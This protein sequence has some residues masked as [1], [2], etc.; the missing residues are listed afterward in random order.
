MGVVQALTDVAKP[1]PAA[2]PVSPDHLIRVTTPHL[3]LRERGGHGQTILFTGR[4]HVGEVHSVHPAGC[5]D[6]RATGHLRPLAHEQAVEQYLLF[7]AQA[8]PVRPC[9][10][11]NDHSAGTV[12]FRRGP[13]DGPP[14][15]AAV[16]HARATRY[17]PIGQT[18][19]RGHRLPATNSFPPSDD[20]PYDSVVTMPSA[21]AHHLPPLRE[22]HHETR[23]RDRPARYRRCLQ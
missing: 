3:L 16:G 9:S 8:I 20:V 10:P 12:H 18:A 21:I 22:G 11:V 1:S 2:L 6:T 4:Q 13:L 14:C 17:A 7:G 15:R 23:R 5:R 19:R